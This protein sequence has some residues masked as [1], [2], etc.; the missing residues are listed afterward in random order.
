MQL[1]AAVTQGITDTEDTRIKNADNVT[2]ICF[3]HYCA[4]LSQELLR[5]CQLNHLTGLLVVNAHSL[6]KD[7]GT[8]THEGNSVTVSRI[9]ISLDFKNK[10]REFF[11]L[12]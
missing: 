10:S 9:H 5:L 3:F 2:W 11:V 4:L 1:Q 7:A 8:N 6:V 12:R